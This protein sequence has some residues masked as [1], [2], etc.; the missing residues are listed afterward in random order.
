MPNSK[1]KTTYSNQ[2]IDLGGR[3]VIPSEFRDKLDISEKDKVEIY[4]ENERI[5]L[6]KFLYSCEFCGD[7]KD[8]TAYRDHYICENCLND[9]AERANCS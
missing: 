4:I 1:N 5:I 3:V 6:K 8:A 7:V 9:L 2:G